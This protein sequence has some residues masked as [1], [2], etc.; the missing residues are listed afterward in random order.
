MMKVTYNYRENFTEKE[1]DIIYDALCD[2]YEKEKEF[3]R[4]ITEEYNTVRVIKKMHY[5]IVDHKYHFNIQ[6]FNDTDIID[7][8]YPRSGTNI[9][10]MIHCNVNTSNKIINFTIKKESKKPLSTFI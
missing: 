1:K 4:M 2:A 10:K 9:S 3:F 5:G 8:E 6:L 7:M